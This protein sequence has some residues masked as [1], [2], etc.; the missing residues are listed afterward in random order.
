LTDAVRIL[1]VD[2]LECGLV[3]YD[4]PFARDSANEIAEHWARQTKL[5][6]ALF[7]GAVLLAN[8]ARTRLDARDQRV[9]ELD[10]FEVRFSQ[11]LR[12]R[13]VGFPDRSVYN[14]FAMP[15]LRSGDGAFLLGEMGP[16]HSCAGQLYFP[17]GTPDRAD[18]VG[19]RVDLDGSVLRELFEETGIHVTSGMFTPGWHVVF[20]SQRIA[21][22]KVI[23]WPKP[24][25]EL[26]E[27]VERHI[28]QEAEPELARGHL[29][30]AR[31]QLAD[32]RLPGFMIAFLDRMLQQ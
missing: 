23:D 29:V 7:D 13:D 2:R 17:A 21:C 20:D 18:V 26:L 30:S 28:S 14:C 16:S 6:P 24:A 27:Q 1:T 11:F 15:A 31:A 4:W 22:M 3:H 8:G 19:D 12:W 5:N 9:L 10:F 32:D 25:K